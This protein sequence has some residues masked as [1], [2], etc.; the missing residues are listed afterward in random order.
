M[1]GCQDNT[2]GLDEEP[3]LAPDQ[4]L[5][6]LSL[7]NHIRKY[8]PSMPRAFL[9]HEAVAEDQQSSLTVHHPFWDSREVQVGNST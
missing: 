3:R 6:L 8:I 5:T 1:S 7:K 2:A 4:A 9:S